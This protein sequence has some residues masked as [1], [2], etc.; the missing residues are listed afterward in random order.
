MS[1]SAERQAFES[2]LNTVWAASAYSTVPVWWENTAFNVPDGVAY[3][4]PTIVSL[5]SAQIEIGGLAD[6][7]LN[8]YGGYMQ[9]DIAVPEETGNDVARK[10]ADVIAN[11]FRRA[12]LEVTGSGYIRCNVP[13][14]V[15]LGIRQGRYRL[16]VRIPYTRDKI[17]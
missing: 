9:I 6:A 1:F 2:K 12:R 4:A 10:M 11:G 7:V 8:R 14:L 16:M 13:E 17:E 15:N 5:P 3:L